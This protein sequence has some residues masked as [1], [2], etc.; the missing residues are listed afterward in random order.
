MSLGQ[1]ARQGKTIGEKDCHGL[2]VKLELESVSA[3][4]SVR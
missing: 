2:K 3:V 4:A 1:G